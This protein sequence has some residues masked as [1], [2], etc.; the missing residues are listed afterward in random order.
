[1][2]L[3][4]IKL[5]GNP[6]EVKLYSS[7]ICGTEFHLVL[8]GCSVW[9][10]KNRVVAERAKTLSAPLW[11]SSYEF[12]INSFVRDSQHRMEVFEVEI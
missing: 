1:M 10:V 6:L 8:D 12:P 9:L 4:G 5:N 11:N 3:F 2:K 7:A